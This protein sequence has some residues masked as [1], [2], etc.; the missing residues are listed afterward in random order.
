VLVKLCA[1]SLSLLFLYFWGSRSS[2][3]TV[4]RV[5]LFLVVVAKF[6]RVVEWKQKERIANKKISFIVLPN[7]REKGW[8][9]PFTRYARVK[10][11]TPMM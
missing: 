4:E 8:E 9:L 6:Y 2:I 5:R 3:K 1:L 11:E 7:E 10:N